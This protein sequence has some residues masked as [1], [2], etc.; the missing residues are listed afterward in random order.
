MPASLTP[1]LYG[2]SSDVKRV[3]VQDDIVSVDTDR[4]QVQIGRV[5]LCHLVFRISLAYGTAT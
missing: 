3:Y 2:A 4:D 1:Y 5:M